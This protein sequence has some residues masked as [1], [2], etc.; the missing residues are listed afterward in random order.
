MAEMKFEEALK[1]LEKIVSDLENGKYSLDESLKRFEEGI[2]LTR[3][4]SK[5]L[6]Q[7]HKRVQMLVKGSSGELEEKPFENDEAGEN[8]SSFE[9]EDSDNKELF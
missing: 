7:A 2:K 3:L 1:K 8:E 5:K 4:C 9:K 6:E